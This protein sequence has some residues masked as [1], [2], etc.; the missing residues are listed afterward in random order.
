MQEG[1]FDNLVLRIIRP[2]S[3]VIPSEFEGR[4]INVLHFKLLPNILTSDRIWR[5]KIESAHLD[6][7]LLDIADICRGYLISPYIG[8]DFQSH[9]DWA[10]WRNKLNNSDYYVLQNLMLNNP[11]RTARITHLVS[12]IAG[13][14]D[15]LPRSYVQRAQAFIGDMSRGRNK[16]GYDAMSLVEKESI[17]RDARMLARDVLVELRVLSLDEYN[18]Q[19]F[20]K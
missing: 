5:K 6:K 2:H 8:I 20:L 13:T 19:D 17:V 12:N 1:P 15:L 18:P 16:P 11:I 3:V 4:R 7:K 10:E 9:L 14:K